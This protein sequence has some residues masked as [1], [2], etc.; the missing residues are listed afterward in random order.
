MEDEGAH[1]TKS[2]PVTRGDED[3]KFALDNCV[4]CG[5]KIIVLSVKIMNS[6]IV[7]DSL[8]CGHTARVLLPIVLRYV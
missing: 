7:G 1:D 8:L 3:N 6:A 5:E 4:I 2:R